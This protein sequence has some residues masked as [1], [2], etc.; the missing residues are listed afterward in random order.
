MARIEIS[1]I[2]TWI[3][4]LILTIIGIIVLIKGT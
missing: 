2:I 4:V 1:D 3:I